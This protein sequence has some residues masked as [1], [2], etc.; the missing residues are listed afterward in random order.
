MYILLFE[1][2]SEWYNMGI[3]YTR[4]QLLTIQEK[5]YIYKGYSIFYLISLF[6]NVPCQIY[7]QSI[8]EK[9]KEVRM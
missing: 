4:K 1:I 6:G 3:I 5:I 2:L 8:K 7:M 9:R